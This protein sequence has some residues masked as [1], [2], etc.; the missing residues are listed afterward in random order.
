MSHTAQVKF[1]LACI[2][3]QLRRH[4]FAKARFHFH[5]LLR[6]LGLQRDVQ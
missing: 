1:N 6:G 3:R 4:N 2:V 5:G